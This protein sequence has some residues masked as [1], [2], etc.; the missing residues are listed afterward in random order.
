[1]ISERVAEEIKRIKASGAGAESGKS[2]RQLAQGRV[3]QVAAA[4]AARLVEAR[5]F[6]VSLRTSAPRRCSSKP[7]AGMENGLYVA[8]PCAQPL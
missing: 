4:A 1:V 3:S 2:L 7:A 8:I 5:H 6:P